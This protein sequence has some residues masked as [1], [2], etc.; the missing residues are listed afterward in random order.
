ML[1]KLLILGIFAGTSASIPI[2]YQANPHLVD[3][4][5][6]STVA[7]Q[8]ATPEAQPQVNLAS[9]PDKP[10]APMPLGRQ[11]LVNA[12]GRGHFTSQFKLNGRRRWSPS[13]PR[14]RAGSASRSTHPT[15]ITR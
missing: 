10:A 4:L 15:S 2:V 12:D 13:T 1:R 7:S 3:G 9:V 14:P 8:P 6:K 11:V 5:L